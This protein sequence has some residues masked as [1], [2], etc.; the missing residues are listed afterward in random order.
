[1]DEQVIP[2]LRGGFGNS[3]PQKGDF[4][5]AVKNIGLRHHGLPGL[6]RLKPLVV[7]LQ[8][9]V[10]GR[11]DILHV[12]PSLLVQLGQIIIDA[13]LSPD[14]LCLGRFWWFGI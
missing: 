8:L 7:S 11:A 4:V 12:L 1:M 2:A 9:L 10:V 5:A 6:E 14:L 3:A 13:C